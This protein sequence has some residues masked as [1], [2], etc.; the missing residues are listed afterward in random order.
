M[1]LRFKVIMAAALLAV[2]AGVA[3]FVVQA[4][5]PAPAPIPEPTQLTTEQKDE[6]FAEYM[7]A[8]GFDAESIASGKGAVREMCSYADDFGAVESVT[9]AFKNLTG[10]PAVAQE[11]MAGVLGAGVAIYCPEHSWAF[12]ELAK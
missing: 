2:V 1:S 11:A 9:I 3:G 8:E 5:A 12:E 4:S 6:V 10:Y 7:S